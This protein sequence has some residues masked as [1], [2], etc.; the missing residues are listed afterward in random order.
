MERYWKIIVKNAHNFLEHVNMSLKDSSSDSLKWWDEKM[1]S[2]MKR[3]RVRWR[4][5]KKNFQSEHTSSQIL[6]LSQIP[7]RMAI[8]KL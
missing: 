4:D 1:K 8:L 5:E 7:F 2:E 6:V 3:W